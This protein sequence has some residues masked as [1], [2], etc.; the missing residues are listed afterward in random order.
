MINL[1]IHNMKNELSKFSKD[2]AE[3]VYS[4]I[5]RDYHEYKKITI[6]EFELQLNLLADDVWQ[7]RLCFS[8]GTIPGYYAGFYENILD[9]VDIPN[10]LHFCDD[11]EEHT[12]INKSLVSGKRYCDD[13]F[14][15]NFELKD[16]HHCWVCMETVGKWIKSDCKCKAIIHLDCYSELRKR[17]QKC[18]CDTSLETLKV[19]V[20][21]LKNEEYK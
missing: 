17:H 10:V 19:T 14:E 20:N 18:M 5:D 1:Y 4:D 3:G 7:I 6:N 16:G 13:C 15:Y 2:V 11:C 12:D 21:Y 8:D 9:F